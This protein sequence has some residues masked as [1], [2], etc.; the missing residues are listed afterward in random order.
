MTYSTITNS[1]FDPV[2]KSKK[3]PDRYLI[4]GFDTEY[5]RYIDNEQ[6]RLENEVLCYQ[7]SCVVVERDPTVQGIH[8]CGLVKPSGPNISD[9]LTLNE[10]IDIAIRTGLSE[11]PEVLLP[12][13]IYLVAH[14]T[15]A[16]V[17]GF[18]DFKEVETRANLQLQNIRN[19]FMNV[20]NDIEVNLDSGISN[21]PISLK[22]KIRDTLSLAPSGARS[23]A[24][25]G[26]ILGFEKIKVGE[27]PEEELSIKQNMKDFMSRDWVK[28]S[29]FLGQVCGSAK[30]HLVCVHAA[31]RI[32]A[33]VKYAV[34]GVRLSS[35]V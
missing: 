22:V 10:F 2:G 9:R 1:N 25:I 14:F 16:D 21:E 33:W 27:T 30:M 34:S 5:Q 24:A 12:R 28:R 18:R 32:S 29:C 26:D 8:W 35:A 7:F 6:K 11:H 31:F 23:L 20:A 19:L 4:I 3:E 17:P 15:R 13:S